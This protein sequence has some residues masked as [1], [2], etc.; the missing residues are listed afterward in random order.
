MKKAASE[1]ATTVIT[2]TIQQSRRRTPN[3]TEVQLITQCVQGDMMVKKERERE[4]K[5]EAEKK[6]QTEGARNYGVFKAC[7]SQ[8][9]LEKEGQNCKANKVIF[10]SF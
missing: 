9:P 3:E 1:A 10:V 6:P 5:K 7:E 8:A 4:R 2:M